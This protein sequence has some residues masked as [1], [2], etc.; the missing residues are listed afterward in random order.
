MSLAFLE[1]EEQFGR[2]WDRLVGGRASLPRFADA[3]VALEDERR[4]L[5]VLFRA[6]GG[7][8]GLELVAGSETTAH[9]RLNFAQRLGMSE[10]R[11]LAAER[12]SELVLLPPVLDCLPTVA[13][14]RD[15]Y[16]W[17]V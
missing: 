13:L 16:V 14:N 3:A 6:M 4:R 8:H 10:E 5:A 17:H 15:L 2:L 12:T 9:H 1:Y 11:L 7:D